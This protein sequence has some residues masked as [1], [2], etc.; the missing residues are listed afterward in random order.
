LAVRLGI[1]LASEEYSPWTLVEQGVEA[2]RMGL[3]AVWG[4][5]HFHPWFES[6]REEALVNS[7]VAC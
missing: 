3:D 2:E 7:I 1:V 5:D 6:I 4:S